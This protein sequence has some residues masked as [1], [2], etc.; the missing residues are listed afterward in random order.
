MKWKLFKKKENDRQ[1]AVIK[2]IFW[3]LF[4]AILYIVLRIS[5]IYS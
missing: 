3:F 1:T 4:I 2:L 5:M